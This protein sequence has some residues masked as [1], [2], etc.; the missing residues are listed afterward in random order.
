M[1]LKLVVSFAF[2]GSI[3]LTL[4]LLS[5]TLT[6][7]DVPIPDDDNAIPNN[8]WSLFVIAF[9]I[10]APIPLVLAR[11]CDN[12]GSGGGLELALF[13]SVGMIVSAF[14]LPCV[15]ANRDVIEWGSCGLVM[16]A[17]IVMF[18]TIG[19]IFRYFGDGDDYFGYSQF[20][21]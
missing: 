3:A 11:N 9:Y 14:A 20:S 21:L 7:G 2:I 17:N 8:C 10:L 15:L 1:S 16:G 19:G 5:C 4:L 18:A 6:F 12:D 13:L